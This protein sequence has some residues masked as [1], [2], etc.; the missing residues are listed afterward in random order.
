LVLAG[1]AGELND[2][3]AFTLGTG[4]ST[5]ITVEA[6]FETNCGNSICHDPDQ[7]AAGLD[8]VSPDVESRTV[9]IASSDANCGSEI[10]VIPGDPDGSYML[11]KIRGRPGICGGQMPVTTLLDA[12]DTAVIEQWISDLGGGAFLD[13]GPDGGI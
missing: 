5:G 10:L 12:E 7:P 8:L 2:P 9:D 3:Q 1:C 13:D 6:V 4:G 11:Q